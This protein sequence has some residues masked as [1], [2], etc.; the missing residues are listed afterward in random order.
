MSNKEIDIKKILNELLNNPESA[1]SLFNIL[2][3]RL[4]TYQKNIDEVKNV[5]YVISPIVKENPQWVPVFA[6]LKS[7]I[8]MIESNNNH[9]QIIYNILE[10]MILKSNNYQQVPD[11]NLEYNPQQMLT[12]V[13]RKNLDWLKQYLTHTKGEDIGQ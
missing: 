7:M 12:K 1:Q 13:D 11:S 10:I 8:P 3:S 5:L 6:L 4:N 9:F 2:E